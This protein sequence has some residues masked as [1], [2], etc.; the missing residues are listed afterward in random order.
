MLRL[1]LTLRANIPNSTGNRTAWQKHFVPADTLYSA[2][3]FAA[4]SPFF[5]SWMLLY[6]IGFDRVFSKDFVD[7]LDAT[8]LDLKAIGWIF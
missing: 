4:I 3:G 2:V 8:R 5:I 6:M 1:L 7:R